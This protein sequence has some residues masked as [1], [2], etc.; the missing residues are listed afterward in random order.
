VGSQQVADLAV[1]GGEPAPPAVQRD[2]DHEVRVGQHEAE[3]ILCAEVAVE[4]AV[5]ACAAAV[6]KS[7]IAYGLPS[8]VRR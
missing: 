2:A 1:A 5:D 3:L 6:M 4:V 8:P 7:E